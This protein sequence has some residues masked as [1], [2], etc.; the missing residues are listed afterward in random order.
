MAEAKVVETIEADI[1]KVW[2]EISNFRSIEPGA[3]VEAVDY[4]GDGVGMVRRIKTPNGTIEERLES[5]D[6]AAH[7]F[8]YAIV[9]DDHPLPFSDY[10]AVVKLEDNNGSTTVNWVGT[11]NSRGIEDDKAVELACG[12]YKNL[13]DQAR[14]AVAG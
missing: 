6:D 2:P 1:D 3:G 12:I 9:N 4:E 10:S 11:F 5:C 14:K 8:S 13:I 7:E